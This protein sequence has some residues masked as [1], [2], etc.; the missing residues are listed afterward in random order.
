VT[1][2]FRI[3]RWRGLPWF[4]AIAFT[5]A[6]VGIGLMYGG[7][8]GAYQRTVVTQRASPQM[9]TILSRTVQ[10]KFSN[11]Q[12]SGTTT[13]T[14]LSFVTL[15]VV[16]LADGTTSTVHQRTKY[17]PVTP[18][19]QMNVVVDPKDP[20]YAEAPGMPFYKSATPMLIGAAIFGIVALVLWGNAFRARTARERQAAV[21]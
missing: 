2:F 8:H 17:G 7:A 13:R 6:A 9:A 1:L 14:S 5:A 10:T 15:T 12:S 16:R 4:F 20:G 19:E 11:A 3:L 18:G 21:A